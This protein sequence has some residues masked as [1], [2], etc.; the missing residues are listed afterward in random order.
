MKIL[1][2]EEEQ[3]HYNATVKGGATGGGIGLLVV[4]PSL[5]I[6]TYKANTSPR[7]ELLSSPPSAASTPSASSLSP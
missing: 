4:C 3:A 7:V 1:T 2:K 5:F 6:Q